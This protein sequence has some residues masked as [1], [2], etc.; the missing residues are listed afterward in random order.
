MVRKLGA[1]WRFDASGHRTI[2]VVQESAEPFAAANRA[3]SVGIQ[4][5]KDR[6]VVEP[7][8]ISFSVIVCHEL[9]N[10]LAN[11]IMQQEPIE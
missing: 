4:I 8:M 1:G 11:N 6:S 3:R 10:G 7:L 9:S 5:G 2:V